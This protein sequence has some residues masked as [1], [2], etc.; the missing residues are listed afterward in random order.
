MGEAVWRKW[1]HRA[2]KNFHSHF[3]TCSSLMYS[4]HPFCL[5]FTEKKQLRGK[6]SPI[7]LLA[8]R[9]GVAGIFSGSTHYARGKKWRLHP[10]ERVKGVKERTG[11][12]VKVTHMQ[13]SAQLAGMCGVKEFAACK[14]GKCRSIC[15]YC[16]TLSSDCDSHIALSL[17]KPSRKRAFQSNSWIISIILTGKLFS[18]LQFVC[19]LI[20]WPHWKAGR[21]GNSFYA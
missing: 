8:A 11:E 7:I 10:S 17:S 3:L 19:N 5:T 21:N 1:S 18:A 15:C 9:S 2:L 14:S 13:N 12:R 20:N 4:S 16:V 6:M